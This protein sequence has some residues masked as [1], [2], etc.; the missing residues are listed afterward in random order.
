MI[1]RWLGR[2]NEENVARARNCCGWPSSPR[3]R[4]LSMLPCLQ[5]FKILNFPRIF[6][7][8]HHIDVF[9]NNSTLFEISKR[10][11]FPFSFSDKD[12][13]RALSQIQHAIF[14]LNYGGYSPFK[15]I[16]IGL[17]CNLFYNFKFD[18][19]KLFSPSWKRDQAWGSPKVYIIY[20]IFLFQMLSIWRIYFTCSYCNIIFVK[21]F[22]Q[23]R[24]F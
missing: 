15:H 17:I 23:K 1:S 19:V 5:T 13:K 12:L 21:Y 18:F 6:S 10:R 4:L 24:F 14:L 2:E 20:N 3:L 16:H 22:L 8:N 7:V 9:C 11:Y